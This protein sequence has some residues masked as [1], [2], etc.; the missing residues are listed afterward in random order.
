MAIIRPRIS[1]AVVSCIIELDTGQKP[2][3]L[4]DPT[5]ATSMHAAQN[6]CDQ[7]MAI[8]PTQQITS[9]R[10]IR[11]PLFLLSPQLATTMDPINAPAPRHTMN[12]PVWNAFRRRNSVVNAGTTCM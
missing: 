2:P 11:R 8:S 5:K 10:Y 1:G 4:V 6:H 3:M 12:T 7:A 9:C